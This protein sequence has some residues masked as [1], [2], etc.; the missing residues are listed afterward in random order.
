[1]EPSAQPPQQ[2]ARTDPNECN[3]QVGRDHMEAQAQLGVRCSGR[4]RDPNSLK[5][6][7]IFL[8]L[9][10][11]A[12]RRSYTQGKLFTLRAGA[13]AGGDPIWVV[14]PK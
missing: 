5:L 13:A 10:T 2:G 12:Y 3:A 4:L 6:G 1:M 9:V 8:F 7:A 11:A 14:N